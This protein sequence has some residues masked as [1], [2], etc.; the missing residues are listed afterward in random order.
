MSDLSQWIGWLLAVTVV[1]PMVICAL[2]LYPV[3]WFAVRLGLLAPMSGHSTHTRA[4]PLGGGIGIWLGIVGTFAIGT[5][6]VFFARH[7]PEWQ[8]RMPSAM[9]PLLDGVWSKAGNLWCVLA[10]GT[11]LT[12]LG[13]TDD[14]RGV[15]EYLRLAIEFA[16]AAFVVYGMGFGLT[17][18]IGVAWLTNLM[19]VIW[20]VGL[21]NSFNMLDNMDGL[22]GGV[23]AIIAGT[24]AT[25]MLM[26]PDPGTAQPQFFVAALLLV[27]FGSLLGFLWH[28]RPPAKIFMGDGG[29]YLI[30]YLVAVA[31]LMATFA[32]DG[33]PRPHA[34]FAPLCVMAVPLYDMITV[35][36]IR[37]REG[38]SLFVGDRSH[39]SHRLV[40]L[41][42]SRTQ[43]VL[44]IYLVTATCGLA[45]IVLTQV[46][47]T[48][49]VMVL[50]I[51][52]CML[53]LVVILES[54]GWR[55]D[56]E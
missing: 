39:F 19:S 52:V 3:R 27:V 21:I 24:M 48:Q 53:L 12:V 56:E 41:G 42:L 38:R 6:A 20:I 29:S 16:V 31:M 36:G 28:N 4:T 23:A 22:S 49:A 33:E 54:T 1:P 44:T 46:P 9:V 51:V 40:D 13:V 45:A 55:K 47:V 18:F 30:G 32:G 8:S 37:I 14:R 26:T 7:A 25:V 5:V 43:A 10:G 34:V 17:A 50:G 2:S 11:V 15:N 35:L